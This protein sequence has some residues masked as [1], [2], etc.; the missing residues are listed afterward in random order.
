[1]ADSMLRT[2][3]NGREVEV[4]ATIPGIREALPE[5]RRP[6]FDRAIAAA[7]VH[8]IHSVMRHWKCGRARRCVSSPY[9][10]GSGR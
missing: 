5:G 7:D 1:M 6:D 4:P 3:S 2:F 10:R 9:R 8:T